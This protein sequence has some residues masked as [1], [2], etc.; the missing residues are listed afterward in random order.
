MARTT[1]II[2]LIIG[3]A[4]AVA[5]TL[6]QRSFYPEVTE[7]GAYS[8]DRTFRGLRPPVPNLTNPVDYIAWLNEYLARGKSPNSVGIYPV[9]YT[10]LTLPT[11]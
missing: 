3:F 2:L 5:F 11:N 6:W 10:H 4:G 9:S 8:A 7:A 1:F